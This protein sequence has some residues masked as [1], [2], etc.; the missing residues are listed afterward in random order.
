MA[1]ETS[2]SLN[3]QVLNSL[4][5]DFDSM[6][7]Q[8]MKVGEITT[9]KQLLDLN[10]FKSQKLQGL[11]GWATKNGHI[12]VVKVLLNDSRVN[13]AADTNYAIRL[14]AANGHVEVVKVL[15]ADPRVDP[16]ADGNYAIRWAAR[17]GHTEVVKVLL[18]DSRVNPADDNNYAIRWAAKNGHL[19]VVKV[20]LADPRVKFF[21][22]DGVMDN[23]FVKLTNGGKVPSSIKEYFS[24]LKPKSD[25]LKTDS[26]TARTEVIDIIE[27]I[28]IE[29]PSGCKRVIFEF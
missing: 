17:N 20:L 10:F 8:L 15:L 7:D 2:I 3:I 13:P 16:T 1:T 26:K 9:I 21:D 14:T 19:E 23:E 28:T 6:I 5:F 29:V 22:E 4:G 24:S 25:S 11:F 12:E 27:P 18:N